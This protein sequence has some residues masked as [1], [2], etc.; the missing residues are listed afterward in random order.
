MGRG[1]RVLPSG[2]VNFSL[3]NDR[4]PMRSPGLKPSL[5]MAPARRLIRVSNSRQVRRR[6]PQTVASLSAPVCTARRTNCEICVIGH[7]SPGIRVLGRQETTSAVVALRSS[8]R[9]MMNG[10]TPILST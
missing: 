3:F 9:T 5:C 6:S 2:K 4:I 7:P 10:W 8:D 1:V